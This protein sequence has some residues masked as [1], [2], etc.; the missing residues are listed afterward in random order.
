VGQAAEEESGVDGAGD[1]G[2]G[3]DGGDDGNAE[4]VEDGEGAASFGNE[5]DAVEG[6]R[7]VVREGG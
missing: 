2:R 1:C 5:D 4:A 7:W 6:G 3:W